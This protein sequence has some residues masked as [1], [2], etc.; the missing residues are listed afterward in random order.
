MDQRKERRL[1]GMEEIRGCLGIVIVALLALA[2]AGLLVWKFFDGLDGDAARLWALVA[3]LFFVVVTPAATWAGWHFGHTEERGTLRGLDVGIDKVMGAADRAI[4]T[5]I[6]AQ[7]ALKQ[8]T[9]DIPPYTIL[10]PPEMGY[11][12]RRQLPSG[13]V[14]DVG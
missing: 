3:T 13:D 4:T 14:I 1:W 6:T 7:R 8:A 5:K 11:S 12:T 2:A 10:P 9:A